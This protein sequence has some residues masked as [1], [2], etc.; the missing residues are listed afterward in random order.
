MPA[1]AS[2]AARRETARVGLITPSQRLQSFSGLKRFAP[3]LAGKYHDAMTAKPR[4]I[5]C[6]AQRRFC[7]RHH[8]E[9]RYRSATAAAA[10]P[11]AFARTDI[12]EQEEE[13]FYSILGVVCEPACS[14]ISQTS[15][16]AR[17]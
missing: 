2:S 14:Y 5:W 17:L 11:I 8:R 15:L 1:H 12:A 16:R 3:S 6:G 10:E 13:D 7:G 4:Q 9:R